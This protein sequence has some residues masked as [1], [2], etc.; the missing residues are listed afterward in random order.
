MFVPQ[1]SILSLSAE[2]SMQGSSSPGQDCWAGC[3]LCHWKTHPE[4]ISGNTVTSV[5]QSTEQIS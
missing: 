3:L 4:Y 1:T 5:E 2:E